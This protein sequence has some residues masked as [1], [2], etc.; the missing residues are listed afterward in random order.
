MTDEVVKDYGV[1]SKITECVMLGPKNYAYVVTK[2]DG[3]AETTIKMKGVSLH[4]KS[5]GAIGGIEG[6]RELADAYIKK[7][8][9]RKKIP[10]HNIGVSDRFK[11]QVQSVKFDKVLRATSCKRRMVGNF[12]L[13]YGYAGADDPDTTEEEIISNNNLIALLNAIDFED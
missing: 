8:V 6:L 2:P 4:S 9:L 5:L 1:G 13:P 11:Q 7:I 3:T 12:T 10:Q